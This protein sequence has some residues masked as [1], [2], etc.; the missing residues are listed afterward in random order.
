MRIPQYGHGGKY[1]NIYS[2]WESLK[3]V[4]FSRIHLRRIDAQFVRRLSTVLRDTA[5]LIITEVTQRKTDL[6]N[7]S[8]Y[9]SLVKGGDR[10]S[11]SGSSTPSQQGKR[12]V[13]FFKRGLTPT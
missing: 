3:I 13:T 4:H 7:I 6:T 5:L 2:P 10:Q 8:R 12:R 1:S 11:Q 9:C